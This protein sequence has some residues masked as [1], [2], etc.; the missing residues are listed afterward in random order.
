VQGG[1]LERARRGLPR[2]AVYPVSESLRARLG[3]RG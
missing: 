3:M 1:E 2:E